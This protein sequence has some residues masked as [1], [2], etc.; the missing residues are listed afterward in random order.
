MS[1]YV[2]YSEHNYGRMIMCHMI[3]D[4]PDELRNMARYIGVQQ[5]WFQ[6]KASTPH[7]DICKSKRALAISAG[8]IQLDRHQF[9]DKMRA[10]RTSWP[11]RGD[12][13]WM[14]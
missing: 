9:V 3:A 2:D 5:R 13:R 1:V 14:F 4:T 11:R 6:D 12:G 8:A 7:F 10:L